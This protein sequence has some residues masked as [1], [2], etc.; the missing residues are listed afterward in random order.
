[1]K[2][3]V[4]KSIGL[5]AV[6]G[7]AF[8]A[9]VAFQ[10]SGPSTHKLPELVGDGFTSDRADWRERLPELRATA[11]GD[12][13]RQ[14]ALESIELAVSNSSRD[15]AIELLGWVGLD[16]YADLLYDMTAEGGQ[17]RLPAVK[18][19]GRL[20]SPAAVEIL[21]ELYQLKDPAIQYELLQ[22][23]GNTGDPQALA[24]LEA[25]LDNDHYAASAAWGL[26]L[27]GTDEAARILDAAFRDQRNRDQ[28]YSLASALA[29]FPPEDLGGP[30]ATLHEALH[31]GSQ[32][33][34]QAAMNAL[35][36][37]KDPQVYEA[38]AE[39]LE[40][41]NAS[42]QTDA[43]S[44][45]GTLNEPRAV[46]GLE[47]I[48]RY[49]SARV[50]SQ[51]VWALGA[52]DNDEAREAL[53][54]IVET[55]PADTASSAAGAFRDLDGE[56]VTEV[57]AWAIDSRGTMVRDAARNRLFQGPWT[58]GGPPDEVLGLARDF[59]GAPSGWSGQVYTFLLEHGTS[60]DLRLCL[61]VLRNGTSQQRS[62]ALW[63]FQSKPDLLTD[64]LLFELLEDGDPNVRRTA[65]QTLQS[66]GEDAT[67]DLEGVLIA[68]LE[69]GELGQGWDDAESILA[70]M[71]TPSANKA[72]MRRISEGTDAEARRALQAVVYN[73]DADQVSALADVLRRSDDPME[74]QRIYDSILYSNAPGLEEFVDLALE[75]DT[76]GVKAQAVYT[77]GRIGTSEARGT[78]MDLLED[79]DIG[80][81]GASL[82]ALATMGGKEA[83]GLLL[84]A[85]DDPEMASTAVSGL[86]TL[87]TRAAREALVDVAAHS[88]DVNL[89]TQ[90]LYAVS[91][92]GGREGEEAI[93]AAMSDD[94]ETVRQ[95][96]F[97][98]IQSVGTSRAAEALGEQLA[99]MDP[100]DPMAY[101]A[102]SALR[103]MGGSAATEHQD[104][105]EE[106][107]GSNDTGMWGLG[108]LGYLDGLGYLDAYTEP[109]LLIAAEG[110][111][112][113]P[114]TLS[115]EV[116][117]ED[118]GDTGM[119]IE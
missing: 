112:I 113:E 53:I 93:I 111:V 74:R 63:A 86:Q 38:L 29:S 41:S 82:Q 91:W 10:G 7:A 85:M 37:V 21:L 83:E 62:E 84:D 104:R 70:G 47:K 27:H 79:E 30:R 96:A 6:L 61:D 12:E 102:A 116:S 107:L 57:L 109:E 4:L 8:G 31:R 56:G 2:S 94:D 19:L 117:D 36:A 23:L 103:S 20:G 90:A 118:W 40:S 50:R 106:I 14:I 3:V 28:L 89:R 99:Q 54:S 65:L 78:L 59:L 114:E 52:M 18:A 75:D 115:D 88:E 67:E 97:S 45:M 35:A 80:V 101:Q 55:G 76:P 119:I 95:T 22:A 49:G 34:R 5:L 77:L 71:G 58:D 13:L 9:G 100:E 32:S 16:E 46:P 26:G 87:G 69:S 98:A 44:A 51:A 24:I 110:N 108:S 72:L 48:A 11:E 17:H 60:A 68:R 81:R 39:A 1:M 15:Q 33:Q 64:D 25:E 73:G 43:I 66:R 105:I 42:I 92:S